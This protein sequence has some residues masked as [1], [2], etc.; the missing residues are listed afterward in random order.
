MAKRPSPVRA[1]VF[2]LDGTLLNSE[3][4]IHAACNHALTHAGRDILDIRAVRSFVGDGARALVARA[5]GL[6]RA[7]PRV[8]EH[9]EVFLGYYHDH[10][11]DHGTL[12]DGA[13]ELLSWLGP[14]RIG[15]CTNKNK[16]ITLRILNCLKLEVA[17]VVGGGDAPQ[18][19]PSPE[20]VW[21]SCDLL[22]VAPSDVVFVGD[23]EQDILAAQAAGCFSVGVLGGLGAESRLRAAGPDVLLSSLSELLEV[24]RGWDFATGV[25]RKS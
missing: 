9:L 18:L 23:S 3:A 22:G 13:M 14:E 11:L 17:A 5:L 25:Q 8:S 10:P 15:I 16:L 19:K 24:F 21:R 20:P 6:D 1:V 12:Y 2:D 7:D 4:D